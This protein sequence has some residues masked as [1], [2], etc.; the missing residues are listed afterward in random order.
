MKGIGSLLKYCSLTGILLISFAY[1]DGLL[2]APENTSSSTTSQSKEKSSNPVSFETLANDSQMVNRQALPFDDQVYDLAYQ[3]FLANRN[4]KDAFLLAQSAVQQNPDNLQWRQR[5]AQMATWYGKPRVALQQWQYLLEHGK[6]EKQHLDSIIDLA[7]GLHDDGVLIEALHVKIKIYGDDQEVWK[8]MISAYERLNQPEKAIDL[9]K[10]ANARQPKELYLLLM[11]DIYDNMGFPQQEFD[12]LNSIKAKYGVTPGLAAR[13]AE[14]LYNEGNLQGA[15]N[16]LQ[17]AKSKAQATDT[18]YWR[19]MADLSWMMQDRPDALQASEVLV[20]S[21]YATLEDYQRLINLLQFKDPQRAFDLS[22]RAWKKYKDPSLYL[23]MMS[24]GNDIKDW[25]ALKESYTALSPDV[26]NELSQIPFFWTT[27]AQ[28]WQQVGRPDWAREAY[29]QALD[30]D[31]TGTGMRAGYIWLL[32]DQK[33]Y[34]TLQD[35]L[36]EWHSDIDLKTDPQLW[37]AAANG[38]LFMGNRPMAIT[39]FQEELPTKLNDFPWLITY[40]ATLENMGYHRASTDLFIFIWD[41]IN[42]HHQQKAEEL[43]PQE[44]APYIETAARRSPGDIY[45]KS[46]QK[47]AQGPHMVATPDILTSYSLD[48]QN[49]ELGNYLVNYYK[50]KQVKPPPLQGLFLALNNND[51]PLMEE[52]LL[53]HAD[54]L[55]PTDNRDAALRM[56]YYALAEQYAY[57]ATD[58][59]PYD[60][61]LHDQASDTLLNG[62]DFVKA[63]EQFIKVGSVEGIQ[64]IIKG[65]YYISQNWAVAPY[66]SY[67]G[68]Q[69]SVAQESITN[70]PDDDLEGGLN[71]DYRSFRNQMELSAGVRDALYTFPTA[72]FNDIYKITSALTG[73]LFLGY[74][75]RAAETTA[76]FVGGVKDN[77]VGNLSYEVTPYNVLVGQYEAD[78]FTDQQSRYLG[79]GNVFTGQYIHRLRLDYPDIAL[80]AFGELHF[81]NGP[82]SLQGRT[83]QLVPTGTVADADFL[84]PESFNQWGLGFDYDNFYRGTYTDR[85][86]PYFSGNVFFNSV[87][88]V[89]YDADGGLKTSVF[90]NDQL[91][92]YGGYSQGAAGQD[93][94]NSVFGLSYQYLF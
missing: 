27:V 9:L 73:Q 26:K 42:Q 70:V 92:I 49:Y 18:R 21:G 62:A 36:M 87:S 1:P 37:D 2:S 28:I 79:Y 13:Q 22:Q 89:G 33:D 56:N 74:N 15:L 54:V 61:L 12:T 76:L 86:R 81:Y 8:Q 57:E 20:K 64:T 32:I 90:G 34:A 16:T 88:G 24:L 71:F 75:Q 80:R 19:S 39:M 35:V 7:Q 6:Q 45:G 43:S 31:P 69:K 58:K 30:Q 38:Y 85:L 59:Y 77:V 68:N 25:G 72:H 66:V 5:L 10:Q 4:L 93:Q 53:D 78:L 55:R 47:F 23:T 84:V 91:D 63:N 40:A 3:A 44:W 60:T 48:T 17:Q 52:Y 94:I 82:G 65:K 29:L 11:A 50:S 46:V 14:I 51:T 67:I 83:T 41:R